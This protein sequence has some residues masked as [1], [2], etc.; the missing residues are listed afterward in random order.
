MYHLLSVYVVIDT[1]LL[2][3]LVLLSLVVACTVMIYVVPSSRLLRVPL[4]VVRPLT[5]SLP[6]L[7]YEAVVVYKMR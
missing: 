6:P 2:L 1:A 3:A 7:V 5:L 4:V